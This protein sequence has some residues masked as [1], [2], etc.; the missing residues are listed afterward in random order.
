MNNPSKFEDIAKYFTIFCMGFFGLLAQTLL[1]RVFL[2]EFDGN[3]LSIGLFFFSW[4]IWVCIGAWIAKTPIISR[5]SNYFYILIILYLPLYIIQQY[6]FI[7]AQSILGGN[8]YE[9]VSLNQLI[10]FVL[11]FNAPISFMTG[12]FFVLGTAWMKKSSFP[13]IKIYVCESLGSFVGA[14]IVTLLL[15]AG[16]VEES[17]FLFAA[18]IVLIS[19]LPHIIRSRMIDWLWRITILILIFIVIF[20]LF[21]GY[22]TKWNSYFNRCEWQNFLQQGQYRGVFLTP[23]AKYLYGTYKGEFIVSAWNSTYESLPNTETSSKLV[24]EYLSQNPNASKILVIGP[25]SFSICRTFNKLPQIR[26]IVWL[27][28]DPDY[29]KKFLK[30][31]PEEYRINASK[32]SHLSQLNNP[33]LAKLVSTV[34]PNINR[35]GYIEIPECDVRKY[36]K[37]SNAKFDLIVLNLPNPS[38]LLLNRYFTLEF[39]QQLKNVTSSKGVVGINFPAGANYMGTEL[40]FVG[41]SLLYTLQ[42]VF[43]YIVLK[44]GDESCFFVAKNKGIVSDTGSVLQKRLNSVKDIRKVFYPE[45]ISSD[46]EANR[47]AFQMK[48]YEEIIKQYP[49]QEFLNMDN[50]P[51]SFLYTLLFTIKKLGN[52]G[53]SIS[54][55]NMILQTVLPWIVLVVIIYFILRLFY[56]YYYGTKRSLDENDDKNLSNVELYFSVFIAAVSGLGINLILIFLF[57]IYFGSVFLYFGIITA[58]FMLGLFISA[59]I[60][61]KLLHYFQCKNLLSFITLLYLLYILLIYFYPPEFSIIYFTFLFLCAGLFCGPYFALAAFGLK[62]QLT[63]IQSAAR[64]DIIDNLGGAIGSLLCSII[65]LPIIGVNQTL[66]VMFLLLGIILLHSLFLRGRVSGKPPFAVNAI[67]IIGFFMLG[68]ALVFVISP[69]LSWDKGTEVKPSNIWTLT[70]QQVHDLTLNN[71]ELIKE[72]GEFNKNQCTYYVVKDGKQTVGYIF[73]T[74]DFTKDAQGYAGPIHLLSYV[75]KKGKIENFTILES[76]ET[77]TYLNEILKSKKIFLGQNVFIN[78]EKYQVNAITGATMT[79]S[80]ISNILFDAGNKFSINILKNKQGLKEIK[81]SWNL[82]LF[83]SLILL[84]IFTIIAIILRYINNRLLRYCFLIVICLILGFGFN[85]QYSMDQLFTL[86]SFKLYLL[87]FN[88][89]LFL[90]LVIPILIILFGNIYCGY[91]CPFGAFIELLHSI[92]HFI[93]NKLGIVKIKRKLS[94]TVWRIGRCIKYIILFVLV[95]LF[96]LIQNKNIAED[97]DILPYIFS[98]IYPSE[99]TLLFILFIIIISLVYKRFWCRVLCPAGAFLSLFN[100]IRIIRIFKSKINIR[101]CDLGVYSTKEIDCICCDNCRNHKKESTSKSTHLKSK[102]YNY[103]FIVLCIISFSYMILMLNQSYS[104]QRES[105]I[106]NNLEHILENQPAVQIKEQTKLKTII[107]SK[108]IPPIKS[109]GKPRNI[110]IQKYKEYINKGKLSNKEAMYFKQVE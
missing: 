18:F 69:F 37:E 104:R 65:L 16:F 17:I 78:P 7:N 71:R 19:A 102:I 67:R 86:I 101:R 5:L 97:I 64:L 51:K 11:L 2:I 57:Q 70:K 60:V 32:S 41:S 35:L 92:I 73:R 12:L 8:S 47:I 22:T 110:N 82:Y 90:C 105:D 58:L 40:S 91:L 95:I 107:F 66:V 76:N 21:S 68:I 62:K 29:P 63:D 59:L 50:N 85:I 6:L 93:I 1:F 9:L 24:G 10:P 81:K 54:E 43:D 38:T 26:K 96:V 3:E 87:Y 53:L 108:R 89:F 27:D 45:N 75:N 13:V 52:I 72:N 88:T 33:S 77:P 98:F 61:E 80:A 49:H 20:I 74:K 42:K 94:R 31:L 46:F 56:Y 106:G 84:I 83:L 100:A 48:R 39:F 36:I 79:S 14:L 23:Q 30:V 25:G 4:L 15:F 34:S 109:I 103:L 28:T 99:G 55:L 44:P